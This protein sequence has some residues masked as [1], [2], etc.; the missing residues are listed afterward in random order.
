[1]RDQQ[2]HSGTTFGGSEAASLTALSKLTIASYEGLERELRDTIAALEG[3]ALRFE[4]AVD[5]ITQGIR[6]FDGDQKLVLCNRRYAE[7]YRIAPE[8]LHPG[9]T[10]TK[11]WNSAGSPDF[12]N[13]W[14]RFRGA[15]GPCRFL[16]CREAK[17]TAVYQP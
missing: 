12:C 13:A 9:L 16:L 3:Q 4:T 6:F 2:N 11:S 10:L 1:M 8:L 14:R 15:G 17:T 7:I 5:N